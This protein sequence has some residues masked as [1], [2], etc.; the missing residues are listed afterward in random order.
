M[1]GNL[2]VCIRKTRDIPVIG[3]SG[4][5][6]SYACRRLKEAIDRIIDGGDSQIVIDFSNVEYMDSYGL[7]T[8]VG[9]LERVSAHDGDMAISGMGSHVLSVLKVTGLNSLF[10]LFEDEDDAAIFL[11]ARTDRVLAMPKAA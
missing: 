4:D 2:E 5:L 6:D 8:L 7:S 9:S 3:L 10:E 11:G 1:E